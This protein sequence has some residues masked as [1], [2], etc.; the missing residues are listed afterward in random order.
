MAID[1][2]AKPAEGLCEVNI[3]LRAHKEL[4]F[5]F[6]STGN[7]VSTLRSVSVCVPLLLGDFKRA[8]CFFEAWIIQKWEFSEF[9]LNKSGFFL[10]T[11]FSTNTWIHVA[12]SKPLGAVGLCSAVTYVVWDKYT[13]GGRSAVKLSF[14][15]SHG[16]TLCQ[17][18]SVRNIQP[19]RHLNLFIK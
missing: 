11:F 6:E 16:L 15:T 3:C 8:F 12:P 4:S 2:V 7:F 1:S 5:G 14:R 10:L 13:G 18:R 17:N 9:L 19:K